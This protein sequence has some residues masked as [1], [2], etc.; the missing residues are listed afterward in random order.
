[1]DGTLFKLEFKPMVNGEE[2]FIS[3]GGYSIN[4]MFICDDCS[5]ITW[6]EIGWPGSFHVF[7]FG[8][9]LNFLSTKKSIKMST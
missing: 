5:R 1:M 2:Y 7:S 9:T 3:K 4:G 8:V 6:A